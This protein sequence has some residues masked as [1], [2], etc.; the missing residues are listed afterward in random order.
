MDKPLISVLIPAYNVERYLGE[1]LSSILSQSETRVEVLVMDDGSTDG[2]NALLARYAANDARLRLFRQEN[3]GAYVARNRLLAE[4]R[5]RWIYFCDADDRLA[6][7][8]FARLLAAAEADD[9][10]F[11]GFCADVFYDSPSLEARF[12]KFRNRYSFSCDFASPCTG[13][14]LFC[15]IVAAG[16]WRSLVWLMFLRRDLLDG[17]AIRFVERRVHSDDIF[18]I[19][20]LLHA[21]KAVRLPD[22]LYFRRMREGSLMTSFHPLADFLSYWHNACWTLAAGERPDRSAPARAALGELV[23][24]MLRNARRAAR[25]LTEEDWLRLA[26][27]HP[28]ENAVARVFSNK[29]MAQQLQARDEGTARRYAR[30]VLLRRAVSKKKRQLLSALRA[31]R[32][33]RLG[34]ALFARRK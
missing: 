22:R 10:D 28:G 13:E 16:E 3:A 24:H 8:A 34:T 6:S 11:V 27:E 21:R 4:A 2:T 30:I 7:G 5:G 12:A 29:R 31:S 20:V 14:E 18:G 19:D 23:F 9:L 26:A 32:A 33:Y 15:K 1:C 25:R 17:N